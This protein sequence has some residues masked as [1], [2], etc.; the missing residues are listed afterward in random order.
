M[1]VA[2]IATTARGDRR[3]PF[4]RNFDAYEGHA[5]ASG[6]APFFDG[7]NQESSSEAIHAW[8]ALILWGEATGDKALRDT[9]IYLYTS[10]IAAAQYYWFDLHRLVFAPEYQSSAAGIVWGSKYT[11]TAWWTE[12]PRE[13]H[14]INLLPLTTASLYLG[15]D[16]AYVQRNLQAMDR[17][18]QRYRTSEREQHAP[19]QIWQD[20]LLQYAA[21]NDPA[22]ALT[23]WDEQGMVE[24][25]ETPS[26]TYHFMQ[27]LANLG[28]PD[29]SV[30]ANTP[31]YGVF[32][33]AGGQRHYLAFNASQSAVS[34][35]FS[36]GMTLRV[37]PR[38]LAQGARK[39]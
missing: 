35:M 2:D 9:G 7:N 32:R 10:E 16:P 28:R 4:L 23:Q 31:F 38:R 22:A 14:G 8:A 15:Y 24:E 37:P 33:T 39:P 36:D 21:L 19:P 13:V 11:H 3:F 30:T 27:S 12:D 17:A 26:H 6:T 25:G 1:L 18:Y 5:W 20:I 34:V 29:F